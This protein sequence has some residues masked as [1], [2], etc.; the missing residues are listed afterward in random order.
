MAKQSVFRDFMR[1]LKQRWLDELPSVHPLEESFS[2]Y[3]PKASTFYAGF[4][5]SLGMHVF[6]RFQHSPK[7]WE[8]GRFTIDLIL[9]RRKGPPDRCGGACTPHGDA[10]FEEGSHRIGPL[11]G[12]RKDKWWHLKEDEPPILT[13][14]WRPSSYEDYDAV[15]SEAVADVSR[16]VRE[17]L[18]K[19]GAGQTPPSPGELG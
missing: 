10:S 5:E 8:A 19:L 13:Q 17:A 18:T 3:M 11:L 14:A 2:S 1:A 4:T 12:Y 15:L 7:A 9:S 6:V 16:D